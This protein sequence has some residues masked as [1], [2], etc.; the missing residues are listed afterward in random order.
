LQI[1]TGAYNRLELHLHIRRW[2]MIN[3]NKEIRQPRSS[4]ELISTLDLHPC[5]I[6]CSTPID[7]WDGSR[8]NFPASAWNSL[9]LEETWF[10]DTPTSEKKIIW[11]RMAFIPSTVTSGFVITSE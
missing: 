8:L 4:L 2:S 11:I 6:S 1:F 5:P 3:R 9:L 10:W 7:K